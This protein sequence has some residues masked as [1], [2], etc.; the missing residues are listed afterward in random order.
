MII[1]IWCILEGMVP[2]IGG[3]ERKPQ[4]K[5]HDRHGRKCVVPIVKRTAYTSIVNATLPVHG[6]KLFNVMLR[7][8]RNLSGCLKDLFIQV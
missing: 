2:N 4:L 5:H 8:V 3:N 6:A 1:Y 7:S